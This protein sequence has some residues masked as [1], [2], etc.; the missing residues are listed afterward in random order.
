[1]T[2]SRQNNENYIG[3]N[4][5]KVK[6]C[7]SIRHGVSRTWTLYENTFFIRP[8]AVYAERQLNQFKG[9]HSMYIYDNNLFLF[10]LFPCLKQCIVF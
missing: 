5:H 2:K 9:K 3:S 4:D 8:D 10:T 1:M 7:I 6:E